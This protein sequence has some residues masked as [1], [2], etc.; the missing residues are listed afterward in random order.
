VKSVLGRTEPR[1][2]TP[3]LRELTP[4]TSAG[5]DQVE[6]ARDVLRYPLDPWEEFAVIH[7]GELLPDGRPRFRIVLLLVSRQNGKTTIPKVLTLHWLYVDQFPMVLG[8]SSKLEYARETWMASINLAKGVP[9]LAA[10]IANVRTAN[11]QEEFA[12]AGGARA[13]I[14]AANGDAGRSLS[15]DRLY[16]DELRQHH[17]YEAWAAAESTM[18]ARPYAQAWLLSNAGSDAS[19][20]LNDLR[21]SALAG[22]DERLGIFE[23]SADDDADPLDLDAL[24]QANPNL[25]RR[26]DASTLLGAARRAVEL[27]GEALTTFKT[28]NMC[29]RVK[30]LDPA[31]DPG[32][33]LRCLDVGDLAAVRSRVALCLD[34]APDGLHATLAAA[35][36]LDDDRTRI[37]IVQAW[38]GLGCTD[39]LRRDLP[40]LLARVKP[41]ALGWLPAGPAAALA[42]DLTD[43]KRPGWPPRGVTVTEIRAEIAAVCMGL[44]EQVT[45]GRIAHSGD[46]LLDAHIGAAQRLKRGDTWVFS[47]K[48]EGHV[49]AAYAAAGAAHL[50]RTLPPPPAR[51][52]ILVGRR[53]AAS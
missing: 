9:D 23:W 3:P 11:G 50:A 47:R 31:I 12:V 36:A 27:G 37:E 38:D 6:F 10:E 43:R 14:A 21:E 17:T 5:F 34:V 41:Q 33:W 44:A 24:A 2:W 15:I 35:A 39:R 4:E 22:V 20:V 40:G 45:A 42:A 18:N 8:V 51:P 7:G 1:L 30:V 16:I 52:L 19:V 49:D 29:I 26:L 48:G 13:K 46:P 32:A 53:P 25:G 28:E